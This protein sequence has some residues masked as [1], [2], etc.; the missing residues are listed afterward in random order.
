MSVCVCQHFI[1]L[2][3]KGRKKNWD[4]VAV[5]FNVKAAKI[6]RDWLK[7]KKLWYIADRCVC[8]NFYNE[9]LKE[10]YIR[11]DANKLFSEKLAIF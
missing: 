10:K 6:M 1:Y 2:C 5:Q 11:L 3:P 4:E 7:I 9:T 8:E